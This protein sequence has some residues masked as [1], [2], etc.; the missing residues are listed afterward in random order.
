MFIVYFFLSEETKLSL[1]LG[2]NF[3]RNIYLIFLYH[4]V[5]VCGSKPEINL[6]VMLLDALDK[7]WSFYQSEKAIEMGEDKLKE[8]L[9]GHATVNILRT[10]SKSFGCSKYD[11]G[12]LGAELHYRMNVS[13]FVGPGKYLFYSLVSFQRMSI[14]CMYCYI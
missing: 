4:L 3:A 9:E 5:I 14:Y 2:M 6:S 12:A 1:V 11:Y 8:I 7:P 10:I 13:A